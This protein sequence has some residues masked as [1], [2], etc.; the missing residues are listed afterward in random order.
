[1]PRTPQFT[2]YDR[3][4][5]LHHYD[6]FGVFIRTEQ[7]AIIPSGTDIPAKSTTIAPPS[8]AGRRVPVFNESAQR[9]SLI[10]DN[11]GRAVFDVV[12][13]DRIEIKALG[14]LPP[15]V[16]ETEPEEGD[17]WNG[18]RWV[19][20]LTTLREIARRQIA[21][22]SE[23]AKR[24][25]VESVG[26]TPDEYAVIRVFESWDQVGDTPPVIDAHVSAGL[27][28]TAALEAVQTQ[29]SAYEAVIEA[30]YIARTEAFYAIDNATSATR[31]NAARSAGVT[32]LNGF[33]S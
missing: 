26:L 7:H 3:T 6:E 15:N 31:I 27:T 25:G 29:V 22:A 12:T 28:I 4:E 23:Q 21:R 8:R 30:V 13:G 20:N 33:Y 19:K 9:W 11:R 17:E 5:T 1:M 14:D 16:T 24:R 10:N 32:T 18:T 2:T